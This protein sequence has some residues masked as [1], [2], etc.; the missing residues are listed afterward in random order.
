MFLYKQLWLQIKSI[1]ELVFSFSLLIPVF[2]PNF[3]NQ[4]FT[5][6]KPMDSSGT[7]WKW[8]FIFFV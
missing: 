4:V 6:L 5:N 1:L 8:K 2:H 7:W 3:L